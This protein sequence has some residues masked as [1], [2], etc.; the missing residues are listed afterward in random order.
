M[1]SNETKPST[2]QL[3]R[4]VK[5]GKGLVLDLLG[6]TVEMLSFSTEDPFCVM[7]GTIPPGVAVP[8][9]SHDDLECFYVLAGE[10]RSLTETENGM[11]WLTLGKGDYIHIA[12]GTRH[13]WFNHSDRPFK[14][15]ITTTTRLGQY[16]S[17]I[18][19]PVKDGISQLTPGEI[20]LFLGRVLEANNRYGYWQ[21]SPEE[22][23]AYGIVLS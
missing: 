1:N 13:A 2:N 22:N 19:R 12:G 7:K 17:E 6:P 23:A 20:Q 14:A 5:P 10:A 9:H 16:F 8:L 18:G 21:G 11:R 4:F 15:L 3:T